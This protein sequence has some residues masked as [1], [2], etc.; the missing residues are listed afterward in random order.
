MPEASGRKKL[1]DIWQQQL[2]SVIPV[3][4]DFILK[5]PTNCTQGVAA[6]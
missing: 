1:P 4:L 5:K 2:H 3:L 6:P